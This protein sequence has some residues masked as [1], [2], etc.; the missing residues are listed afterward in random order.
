VSIADANALVAD[1]WLIGTFISMGIHPAGKRA[2]NRLRAQEV[3]AVPSKFCLGCKALTTNG[4]RC[5]A[6][7]AK[8]EARSN[9]RP[10]ANTTAR[11]LGWAHQRKAKILLSQPGLVCVRCGRPGTP[12]DPLTAGHSQ[13]RSQGGADSALQPEHR[14]CGSRDGAQLGRGQGGR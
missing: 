14:S 10:K 11:G 5:E 1:A 13:A 8:A 2:Y 4:S 9:A 6:C 7:Q 3:T 12:G